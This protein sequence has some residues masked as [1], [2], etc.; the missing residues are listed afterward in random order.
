MADHAP[1]HGGDKK[2]PDVPSKGIS[3]QLGASSAKSMK[4]SFAAPA[5]AEAD[6]DDEDSVAPAAHK[7]VSSKMFALPARSTPLALGFNKGSSSRREF[8]SSPPLLLQELRRQAKM[9]LR[10]DRSVLAPSRAPSA[11]LVCAC[12]LSL[13]QNSCVFSFLARIWS[14][15]P[16]VWPSLRAR[17]GCPPI[18]S[19]W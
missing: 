17:Y 16:S 12:L 1:D 8:A 9:C 13:H 10:W 6:Q 4:F 7:D 15:L 14:L 2:L 18:R 5:A 19:S 11:R 3:F